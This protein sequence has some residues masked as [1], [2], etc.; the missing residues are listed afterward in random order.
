MKP[1]VSALILLLGL[2]QMAFATGPAGSTGAVATVPGS[3]VTWR[4]GD[5]VP[6]GV[7]TVLTAPMQRYQRL[8]P[9]GP[10]TTLRKK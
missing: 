8:R 4:P 3:I 2:T 7:V 10:D 9:M 5:P 6:P 1:Y